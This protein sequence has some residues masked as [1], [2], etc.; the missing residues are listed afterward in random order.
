MM[1]E[2][3][4]DFDNVQKEFKLMFGNFFKEE[5]KELFNKY[6]KTIS[7]PLDKIEKKEPIMFD[8]EEL[9]L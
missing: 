5:Q 6:K 2:L 3:N 8:P 1:T 7:S 9:D 4:I